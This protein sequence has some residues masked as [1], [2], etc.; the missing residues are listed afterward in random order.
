MGHSCEGDFGRLSSFP[1]ELSAAVLK[2][3]E[4]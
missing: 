2:S 4:A 3:G 1:L